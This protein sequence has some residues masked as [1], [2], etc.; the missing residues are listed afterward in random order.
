MDK[1]VYGFD[2]W[3]PE[4]SDSFQFTA[5]LAAQKWIK[6]PDGPETLAITEGVVD[7]Y[8][9]RNAERLLHMDSE[10]AQAFLKSLEEPGLEDEESPVT[11]GSPFPEEL[12]EYAR[13]HGYSGVARPTG[14]RRTGA[15]YPEFWLLNILVFDHQDLRQFARWEVK[16]KGGESIEGRQVWPKI[17][18]WEVMEKK[19]KVFDIKGCPKDMPKSL[20]RS[21]GER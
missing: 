4:V 14:F 6:M 17:G 19:G 2:E 9:L 3:A 7:G 21:R 13:L 1:V 16:F 12:L 20:G 10:E 11:A 8:C 18:P 5:E 15:P